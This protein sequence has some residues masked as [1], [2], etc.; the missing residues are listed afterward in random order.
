MNGD[1]GWPPLQ[2]ILRNF[3]NGWVKDKGQLSQKTNSKSSHQGSG[4]DGLREALPVIWQQLWTLLTLQGF[5]YTLV[6]P[7]NIESIKE[8]V[9]HYRYSWGLGSYLRAKQIQDFVSLVK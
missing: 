7:V 1:L 6:T 4:R 5:T 3:Q 8:I 2:R 9:N